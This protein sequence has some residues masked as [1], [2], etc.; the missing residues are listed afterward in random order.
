[1][2]EPTWQSDDN[3]LPLS[4]RDSVFQQPNIVQCKNHTMSSEKNP[5][6]ANWKSLRAYTA[7]LSQTMT[8]RSGESFLHLIHDKEH[9]SYFWYQ[10]GTPPPKA[11][12]HNHRTILTH[13]TDTIHLCAILTGFQDKCLNYGKKA[14]QFSV[15]EVLE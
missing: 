11:N 2:Y 15:E 14:G 12:R 9:P 7:R 4:R 3:K 6:T 13:R 5:T 10:M 1:M 8:L